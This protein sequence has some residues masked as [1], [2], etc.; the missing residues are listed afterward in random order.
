VSS[1]NKV[2]KNESGCLQAVPQAIPISRAEM[3]FK[4]KNGVVELLRLFGEHGVEPIFD[5]DR[6]CV[7]KNR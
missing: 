3:K 5:I 7:F 4:L 2:D 1:V 6:K